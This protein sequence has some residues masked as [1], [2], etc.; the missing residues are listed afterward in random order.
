MLGPAAGA[1]PARG[2]QGCAP[3]ND[4]AG[5]GVALIFLGEEAST[6]SLNPL[7]ILHDGEKKGGRKRTPNRES[8]KNAPGARPAGRARQRA[9][10]G[11]QGPRPRD[12]G[13]RSQA[14]A[15]TPCASAPQTFR[16]L[17][18]AFASLSSE[19][20]YS[21][22]PAGQGLGK[23]FPAVSASLRLFP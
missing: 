17:E 18:A 8:G 23:N 15:S 16:V 4:A 21:P 19:K 20:H 11:D 1:A 22:S 5:G 12:G 3:S 6:E 13:G 2:G 7:S 10:A 9:C 14:E